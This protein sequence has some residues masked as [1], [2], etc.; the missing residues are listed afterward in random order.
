M[1]DSL[2]SIKKICGSNFHACL[3]ACWLAYLFVSFSLSLFLFV[4]Y[5]LHIFAH[6]F[7]TF[8]ISSYKF[9]NF[10]QYIFITFC[11]ACFFVCVFVWECVWFLLFYLRFRFHF[12]FNIYFILALS[13]VLCVCVCGVCF[14]CVF[15]VTLILFYF[16]LVI[17]RM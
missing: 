5:L 1:L 17:L 13:E 9:Y 16:S 4:C 12:R 10:L 15:V 7:I 6:F 3:L 2:N 8:T 14:E 11:F